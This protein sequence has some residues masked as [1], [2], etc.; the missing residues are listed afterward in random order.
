MAEEVESRDEVWLR[1]WTPMAVEYGEYDSLRA[2][3]IDGTDNTPHDHGIVRA[4]SAKCETPQFNISYTL[5][6]RT[7]RRW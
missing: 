3:S 4:M 7:G 5:A 1:N 6:R 2:G